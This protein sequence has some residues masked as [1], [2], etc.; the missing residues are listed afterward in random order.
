MVVLVGSGIL[1]I[2]DKEI[3]FIEKD[4]TVSYEFEKRP[5]FDILIGISPKRHIIFNYDRPIHR[6][7]EGYL[8]YEDM[9]EV[10]NGRSLPVA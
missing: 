1:K 10:N 4:V 3:G 9:L 5:I 2:G 7:M 6:Q 8:M